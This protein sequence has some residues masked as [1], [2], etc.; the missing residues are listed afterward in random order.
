MGGGKMGEIIEKPNRENFRK[1]DLHIHTPAS[2]YCDSDSN[3]NPNL[4]INALLERCLSADMG[5]IALTDHNSP[6]YTV[7]N[8]PLSPTYY[9]L[10][11]KEIKKRDLKLVVLP[12]LELTTNGYHLL[13]IFP[14]DE[15]ISFTLASLL[16]EL[17]IKPMDWGN[18]DT[19]CSISPNEVLDAIAKR[20]GII[21]PAH[22]DSENG[23]LTSIKEK[24]NIS[25]IFNHSNIVGIEYIGEVKPIILEKYIKNIRNKPLA[26]LRGSNN[27]MSFSGINIQGMKIGERYS[28]AMME[29]NS[30]LTL[31]NVLQNPEHN[32]MIPDDD[33]IQL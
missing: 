30:F 8:D 31:K 19:C 33:I 32:L 20:G 21:I 11:S 10:I 25:Q 3:C 16:F 18:E 9:D 1:I 22:I 12:G 23:I 24:H 28:I 4:F 13:A 26:Y 29:D 27:H 17:G 6:G 14:P 5:I 2:K 15:Y 7:D